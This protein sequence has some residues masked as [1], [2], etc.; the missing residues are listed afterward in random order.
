MSS[1]LIVAN[2]GQDAGIAANMVNHVRAKTTG[3]IVLHRTNLYSDPLRSIKIHPNTGAYDE[4]VVIS[5]ILKPHMIEPLRQHTKVTIIERHKKFIDTYTRQEGDQLDETKSLS[6]LAYMYLYPGEETPQILK[7]ISDYESWSFNL[8]DTLPLHY[9]LGLESCYDGDFIDKVINNDLP[10]LETLINKGRIINKYVDASDKV[11]GEDTYRLGSID[12][13]T[14][15]TANTRGVSSLFFK[16][17]KQDSRYKD[18]KLFLTYGWYPSSQKYRCSIYSEDPSIDAGTIANK[19]FGGGSPEVAGFNTS[20]ISQFLVQLGDKVEDD[21]DYARY[22]QVDTLANH[23]VVKTFMQQH[24]R[25]LINSMRYFSRVYGKSVVICNTPYVHPDIW[26]NARVSNVDMGVACA[27][28]GTG[29]YRIVITDFS[30]IDVE[31]FAKEIDG[32]VMPNGTIWKYSDK[33][34]L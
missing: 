3:L 4:V 5:D 30:G 25:I 7:Y 33:G 6:E 1:L 19:F 9:G 26:F 24:E 2:N 34:I 17:V 12:G 11:I 32:K 16:H 18:I 10:Y 13:H 31:S 27:L 28:L 23:P 20:D 15:V 14:C 21:Y 29:R 8:E 22:Q